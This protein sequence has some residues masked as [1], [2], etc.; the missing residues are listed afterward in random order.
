MLDRCIQVAAFPRG[1]GSA[2]TG[3]V[4]C[5]AILRVEASFLVA[6]SGVQELVELCR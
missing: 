1:L 2:V 6:V 5:G 4:Y 3:S